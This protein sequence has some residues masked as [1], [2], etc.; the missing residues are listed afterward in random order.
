[1]TALPAFK[2]VL[3]G[4]VLDPWPD[5]LVLDVGMKTVPGVVDHH[6]PEAPPECTASLL[7]KDPGLVLSHLPAHLE[8]EARPLLIITH[9]LPDFDALASI[10]ISLKLLETG[11]TESSL[12]AL[13]AYTKQVD[14]ASLPK[15]IELPASPYAVLRA[16]FSGG[17]KEE[18]EANAFRVREGM[19]F[20]RTF[21]ERCVQGRDILFDRGLFRGIDRYERAVRKAEADHLNYLDD[22]DRGRKVLLSLPRDD[23]RGRRT[24]DGLLIRNPRSFL[25]KEWARRDM[26][27]SSLGSGYSFLLMDFGGNRTILGVDPAAGVYLKGLVTCL[28]SLEAEKRRTLGRPE[29]MRWYEG[30]CPLFNYRIIDSPQDG[31]SLDP[32]EIIQTVLEFGEAAGSAEGSPV[33]RRFG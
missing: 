3:Y 28:N 2:F 19:T 13:S 4:E 20:M 31:S 32:Q 14:S 5:T 29:E 7:T 8:K 23:G 15:E 16:L 10:F 11:R 17:R 21:H 12:E 24:V 25:L 33:L 1:M 18:G 22:R 9:R 27:G 6:H 30:N 26:E